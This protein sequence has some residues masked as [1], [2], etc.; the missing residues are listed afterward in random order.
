MLTYVD[1]PVSTASDSIRPR[2]TCKLKKGFERYHDLDRDVVVHSDI[3][4]PVQFY[5]RNVV[6]LII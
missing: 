3:F 1:I 5:N 6:S 4:K 2:K